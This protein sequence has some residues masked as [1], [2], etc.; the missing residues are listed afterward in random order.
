MPCRCDYM[1]PSQREAESKRVAQLLCFVYNSLGKRI[2]H[3]IKAASTNLYGN[4][5]EVDNYTAKLC[6]FIHNFSEEELN[7]IVYDGRNANSRALA[8]WYD[9]H[10]EHDRIR[11]QQISQKEK[12]KLHDELFKKFKNLSTEQMQAA[13]DNVEKD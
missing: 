3:D 5:E 12:Q 6:E 10:Q 9:V 7:S 13:L 11:E 4:V 2:P 1:E 8:D